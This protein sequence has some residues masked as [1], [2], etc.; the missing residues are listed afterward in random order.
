MITGFSQDALEIILIAVLLRTRNNSA[1]G[2]TL[3]GLEA[4][5]YYPFKHE[6]PL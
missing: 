2:F 5:L 1:E 3:A 6:F 4:L